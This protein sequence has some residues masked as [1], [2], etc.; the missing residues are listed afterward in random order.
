MGESGLCAVTFKVEKRQ[1]GLLLDVVLWRSNSAGQWTWWGGKGC[2]VGWGACGPGQGGGGC[3]LKT[4]ELLC[5]RLS[6]CSDAGGYYHGKLVFPREFPFKPP[7]IYMITP[8][9][10]FKCNTR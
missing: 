2:A 9:G 4:L 1:A 7:S 10:R 8:N 5:D 6:L 3:R